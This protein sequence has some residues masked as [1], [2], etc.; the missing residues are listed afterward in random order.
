MHSQIV[1]SAGVCTD[2]GTISAELTGPP[3]PAPGAEGD[4]RRAFAQCSTL[5]H[6]V[7]QPAGTHYVPAGWWTL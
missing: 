5:V 6:R 3:R 4:Q 1:T 2:D 7:H